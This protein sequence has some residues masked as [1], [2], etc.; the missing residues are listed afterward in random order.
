MSLQLSTAQCRDD[1]QMALYW[2]CPMQCL[3]CSGNAK[4]RIR[5]LYI[6]VLLLAMGQGVSYFTYWLFSELLTDPTQ[7]CLP[8]RQA[9]QAEKGAVVA[10]LPSLD[11][12]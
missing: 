5:C 1:N 9:Y 2:H 10:D 6:L 3:G 7:Q 12:A 4:S 11:L 8:L